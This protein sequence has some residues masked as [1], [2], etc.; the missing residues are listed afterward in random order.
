MSKDLPLDIHL[1]NLRTMI[2]HSNKPSEKVALILH[3]QGF[4]ANFKKQ[5]ITVDCFINKKTHIFIDKQL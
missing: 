5:Y 1:V 3:R 2:N 4:K